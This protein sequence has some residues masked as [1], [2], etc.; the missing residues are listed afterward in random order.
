MNGQMLEKVSKF[1]DLGIIIDSN[2]KWQ[3][4]IKT[5]V[6]KANG[7][8]GLI[9]RTFGYKAP[10]KA[11]RLLYDSFIVKSMLTLVLHTFRDKPIRY[12]SRYR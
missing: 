12:V 3:D 2:L 1:N 8:L 7:T 4:H 6:G 11:K 9:K 5:K 10:L